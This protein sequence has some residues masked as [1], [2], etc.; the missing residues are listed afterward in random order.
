MKNLIPFILFCLFLSCSTHKEKSIS[1]EQA[2]SMAG[3]NRKELEKVLEYYKDDSL[4]L[5]AA[6]YLIVNMPFH[7]SRTEYFLSPDNQ[8]YVPDITLFSNSQ[9]VENHC[10]SLVSKGYEIYKEIVYDSKVLNSDYLIRN[11]ELAFKAWQTPWAKDV[12]FEDFCRYILPYRSQT[13]S[14]SN[15]REILLEH[16]LQLLDTNHI[17]NSFDACMII[18]AQLMADLKYKKTGN[19]LYPTIEETYYAKT[20]ECEA[21]CNLATYIMRA[22][23]IPIVIQ[24]TIWTRMDMGHNWCAVLQDGK[25]YDFSPAYV[26]PDTYRNRLT[27]TNYL[28][29]AKI[30]RY[31]FGPNLKKEKIKD[32]GFT[33]FLKS[34]L[35]SDVTIEGESPTF[36]LQVKTDKAV[37]YTRKQIYLCTYNNNQWEPLAIGVLKDSICDFKNVAGNNIFIVAE[38]IDQNLHYITS[39]FLAKADGSIHKFRPDIHKLEQTRF[40]QQKD[41]SSVKLYY[42]DISNVQFNFINC[43]SI[44]NGF[45]QYTGIPGNSLLMFKMSL[46]STGQLGF[47]QGDTLINTRD[48]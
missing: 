20:G 16:Y 11:I 22:A 39:P 34:P 37:S 42:W 18:N 32:D 38:A 40:P 1:L 31:F 14:I 29:P 7:F 21:L 26:Q 24:N 6:Q 17:K 9:A 13:E 8:Q 28:K 10:D 41:N 4:K 43:D 5:K 25:F 47:I 33:T 44:H 23:G 45:Q 19:P 15:L 46:Q 27:T 2:L 35:L 30:Y 3:E 12:N 36:N 48:L